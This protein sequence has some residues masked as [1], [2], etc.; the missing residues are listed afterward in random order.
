MNMADDKS[1]VHLL[2]SKS[3]MDKLKK[4][5][6]HGLA[7]ISDKVRTSDVASGDDVC[8]RDDEHHQD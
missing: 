2:I 4:G 8:R 1:V 6:H 3:T 7:T 5:G